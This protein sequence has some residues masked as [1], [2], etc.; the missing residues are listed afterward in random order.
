MLI[1]QPPFSFYYILTSIFKTLVPSTYHLR[2]NL[3]LLGFG[4]ELFGFARFSLVVH[5]V[6]LN[7]RAIKIG[8]CSEVLL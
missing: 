5:H 8:G 1:V 3:L 7:W 2:P 6:E 4:E